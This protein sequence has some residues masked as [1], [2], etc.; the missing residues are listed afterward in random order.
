MRLLFGLNYIVLWTRGGGRDNT[1]VR[2]LLEDMRVF[3]IA[4]EL[5]PASVGCCFTAFSSSHR[6]Y[7]MS[8]FL[9]LSR[10]LNIKYKLCWA[11]RM[12]LQT[13]S[14]KKWRTNFSVMSNGV[15]E[16]GKLTARFC[17]RAYYSVNS[18][19]PY[20]YLKNKKT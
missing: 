3:I 14:T 10:K 9:P 15:I 19:C 6:F 17:F 18:S 2:Y 12:A 7:Y 5:P 4:V 8:L 11:S 13:H 20:A 16:R 1:K